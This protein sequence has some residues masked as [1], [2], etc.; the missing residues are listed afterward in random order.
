MLVCGGQDGG[1]ASRR[2]L[3]DISLNVLNCLDDLPRPQLVRLGDDSLE[4][5]VDPTRRLTSLIERAKHHLVNLVE[6]MLR[7][8]KDEHSSEPV[9]R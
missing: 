9:C 8:E 6:P 1:Q 5:P 7:V 3:S 2:C 4:R